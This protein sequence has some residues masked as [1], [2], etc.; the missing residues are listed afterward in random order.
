MGK[1]RGRSG[2]FE[3]SIGKEG[4]GRRDDHCGNPP[5]RVKEEDAKRQDANLYRNKGKKDEFKVP[6]I[7]SP[8]REVEDKGE[9]WKEWGPEEE[10]QT[11][12]IKREVEIEDKGNNV[13][14]KDVNE[15]KRKR[16]DDDGQ[17]NTKKI[18]REIKPQDLDTINGT[19]WLND[20]I[21]N[22]YMEL[23]R[24]DK[25]YIMSTFFFP[26]LHING[27]NAV[28]RWTKKVDIF[29]YEKMIVPI[30]LDNHWCLAVIDFLARNIVYYDSFGRE[31]PKYLITLRKYLIEEAKEK[32]NDQNKKEEWSLATKM[33]IPRQMNGYDC[34]VFVCLYAKHVIEKKEM[35]F[36]QQEMPQKRQ[37][38][39][40]ELETGIIEP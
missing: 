29:K 38:I 34:G 16:N 11:K 39:R 22:N 24:D 2:D 33:D 12:K 30:N 18:R 25:T 28:R 8:I 21:I 6:E 4:R 14:N 15:K 13:D 27:Y 35:N 1:R 32:G 10:K 31:N 9:E 7:L 20:E 26:R 36:T 5:A 37:Q 19:N 23:I 17:T 40:R 3:G